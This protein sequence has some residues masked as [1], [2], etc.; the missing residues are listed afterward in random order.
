M[1]FR[2]VHLTI[3][4]D[5]VSIFYGCVC[6]CWF[7]QGL[8]LEVVKTKSNCSSQKHSKKSLQ[9]QTQFK[10]TGIDEAFD[11]RAKLVTVFFSPEL[12]K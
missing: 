5:V 7:Y 8:Y 1:D 9:Q 6:I 4:A 12:T 10:Y 11:P 2:S 3:D